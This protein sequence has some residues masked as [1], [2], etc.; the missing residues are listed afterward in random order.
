MREAV[1]FFGSKIV[2]HKRPCYGLN[3]FKYLK[4]RFPTKSP[5]RISE[6]VS[7]GKF[8]RKHRHWEKTYLTRGRPWKL[9]GPM[10]SLPL[11][12]HIGVTHALGYML[13]NRL[14]DGL[15]KGTVEKKAI[16]KLFFTNFSDLS[17]SLGIY[18]SSISALSK[19]GQGR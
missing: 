11:G 12:I 5:E 14:F 3:D 16:R 18:L 17:Q 13:G 19:P 9:E 15:M 10:F 7:I 8:V 4:R 2:N 1:G 6:M